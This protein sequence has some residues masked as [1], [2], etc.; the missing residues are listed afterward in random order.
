MAARS[1]RPEQPLHDFRWNSYPH[2]L[3]NGDRRKVDVARRLREETTISL[4]RRA[5]RLDME[6]WTCVSNLLRAAP[7]A[8][9]P[10]QQQQRL[11]QW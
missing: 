7:S 6:S 11:C 5:E 1:P 8:A 10:A 3:S 4:K 2:C 9:P